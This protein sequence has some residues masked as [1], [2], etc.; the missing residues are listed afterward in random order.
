MPVAGFLLFHYAVSP[1]ARLNELTL[2]NGDLILR[3]GRS[4]ESFAI[5]LADNNRDFSHIGIVAM[6][7]GKP[8]VIHI[9]PGETGDSNDRVR[10]E[11]PE[12]FLSREKAS[13]FAVYRSIFTAEELKEVASKAMEYFEKGIEFD[14]DYDLVSDQRL[15][16]TELV[17]KAY[18][19]LPINTQGFELQEVRILSGVHEILFPGTFVR[20]PQFFLLYSR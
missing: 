20:S 8:Y 14:N 2:Q 19:Q 13:R 6:E 17:L 18:Q 11:R 10:K 1:D 5:F 3:R 12:A 16:C 15:Y 9:V 4:I 7:H